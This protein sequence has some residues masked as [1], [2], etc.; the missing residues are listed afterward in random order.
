M[1]QINN[2]DQERFHL[3]LRTVK[4]NNTNGIKNKVTHSE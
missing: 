4:Y 2:T 1:K 3:R